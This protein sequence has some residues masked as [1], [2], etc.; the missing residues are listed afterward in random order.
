[1]TGMNEDKSREGRGE[2]CLAAVA[3]H[4]TLLDESSDLSVALS[5]VDPERSRRVICHPK[6]PLDEFVFGVF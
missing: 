6:Q 4:G 3:G 2:D 5:H 1:M